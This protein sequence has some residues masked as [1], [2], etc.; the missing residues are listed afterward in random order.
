MSQPRCQ[1]ED[2]RFPAP[3]LFV[4][5]LTGECDLVLDACR[6]EAAHRKPLGNSDKHERLAIIA[7]AVLD[8]S[9][10]AKSAAFARDVQAAVA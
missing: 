2:D 9:D 1:G 7:R 8:N 4:D 6:R 5:W 10:K 3:G